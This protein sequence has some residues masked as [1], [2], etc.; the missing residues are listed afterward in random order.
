KLNPEGK[1]VWAKTWG[2]KRDDVATEVAVR[3]DSIVVVGQFLDEIKIG[4]FTKKSAGSEDLFV[5]AFD[6]AGEAQWLWTA[7]G[8]DSDGANTVAAT[9]DGGWIVGGSY[10]DGF[11][12]GTTHLKSKGRTDGVL[13]KLKAGGD[14]EWVKSFGGRYDDTVL[15]VAVDGQNSIIAQG[16]FRDTADWGGKPLTAGGGSDNDI[17]LAKYDANGDH[18]W[19]QGFGNAFNDVAGGVGVDPSGHIIMVGSFDKTVTFGK[20]DTHTALGESDIYV[21]RFT[22]E[23]KLAWAKTYGGDR[24]DQGFGIAVD[25]AGNSVATGLFAGTVDFGKGAVSSNT[26]N[27]D[28]FVIKHDANGAVV[29]VKTFGD[30]DHD[31]GR[32]AAMDDKGNPTVAGTFRFKLDV[33][34]P[35]LESVRAEGDRIPKVDTYVLHLER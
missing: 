9:A 20:G 7:G 32:A 15:H 13:I 11:D 17:L 23:G 18:V 12:I 3:G 24:E 1:I 31:H 30:K 2:A 34:T 22:P 8:I 21:A 16:H 29:W 5:V 25:K 10:T 6:T 26:I 14:T 28:V 27:K 19:S 33:V 4:E 35:P